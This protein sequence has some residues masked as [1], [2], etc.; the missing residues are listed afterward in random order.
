MTTTELQGGVNGLHCMSGALAT[1]LSSLPKN[2][3][4]AFFELLADLVRIQLLGAE[5][6]QGRA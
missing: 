3:A 1:A 2:Q 4:M 5:P 6:D